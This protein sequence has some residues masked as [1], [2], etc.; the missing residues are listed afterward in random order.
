MRH[1]TPAKQPK[2]TIQVSVP[3]PA[4][5]GRGIGGNDPSGRRARGGR[6]STTSGPAVIAK[7]LSGAAANARERRRIRR[8]A[9]RAV[10]S[11]TRAVMLSTSEP[12]V[13]VPA[14]V[15]ARMFQ[16]TGFL[17]KLLF[18]FLQP[19]SPA[20]G[21]VI[22]SSANRES[23]SATPFEASGT[24]TLVI[25]A[26]QLAVIQLNPYVFTSPT[27][28]TQTPTSSNSVQARG[29]YFV[30]PTSG[31]TTFADF[32][33]PNHGTSSSMS[34]SGLLYWQFDPTQAFGTSSGRN[35][36]QFM[37]GGGTIEVSPPILG[38]TPPILY[39]IDQSDFPFELNPGDWVNLASAIQTKFSNTTTG[40]PYPDGLITSGISPIRRGGVSSV[41]WFNQICSPAGATVAAAGN[42]WIRT[43][44]GPSVV[45]WG[46]AMPY[47]E[48]ANGNP[49]IYPNM[50]VAA[51]AVESYPA[52]WTSMTAANMLISADGLCPLTFILSNPGTVAINA[53]INYTDHFACMPGSQTAAQF[54]SEIEHEADLSALEVFRENRG[55]LEAYGV[56]CFG[57][58]DLFEKADERFKTKTLSIVGRQ[59]LPSEPFCVNTDYMGS[60]CAG[61]TNRE[62]RRRQAT[63]DLLEHLGHKSRVSQSIDPRDETL[64]EGQASF[65]SSTGD[66]VAKSMRTAYNVVTSPAVA[67]LVSSALSATYRR[68]MN[69]PLSIME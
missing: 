1:K 18:N 20:S 3:T 28:P 27:W 42:P 9:R 57:E 65:L 45:R 63:E 30:A 12:D 69:Q 23:V 47:P 7:S 8:L 50:Y 13:K 59:Y 17:T 48:T 55:W 24:T 53:T 34:S 14:G 68:R 36:S 49:F 11:E 40:I 61:P 16:S 19:D 22:G 2:T 52:T 5:R 29:M 26:G 35:H 31:T 51:Q 4:S 41:P 54:F 62:V 32:M 56:S 43:F 25:P 39:A 67:R 64:R 44:Q 21:G 38:Q 6:G 15:G 60:R 37:G 58:S 66:F 33:A 10:G 46:Q